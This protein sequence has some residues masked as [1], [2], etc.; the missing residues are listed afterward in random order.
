[1]IEKLQRRI[2]LIRYLA[3]KLTL[4]VDMKYVNEIRLKL[5]T[6]G[7][8]ITFTSSNSSTVQTI[9]RELDVD[10]SISVYKELQTAHKIG[11][12]DRCYVMEML[13]TDEPDILV[14]CT[15]SPI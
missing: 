15:F 8:K 12:P 3:D 13:I 2:R 9:S 7:G 1:M 4:P 6:E 10:E 14:T 5:S 11:L